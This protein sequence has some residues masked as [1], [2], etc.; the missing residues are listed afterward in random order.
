VAARPPRAS[1]RALAPDRVVVGTHAVSSVLTHQARR[2]EQLFV[3]DGARGGAIAALAVR[4]QVPVTVRTKDELDSL[5]GGDLVHQGAV[6]ACRPFTF[7]DLDDVVRD[8]PLLALVLDGVVDPRNFGRAVRSAHALGASFV[9][10]PDRHAASPTAAA[11]KASAGALARVPI[12]RFENL[13]RRLD[14][15]KA[16]GFWIVGA[17]ADASRAPWEV[18]LRD[19]IALVVGGEDRGLRRLTREACD[20]VVSIPMG[21]EDVSLN[22]ADAATLLLYEALR[23]RRA[24]FPSR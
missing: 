24:G 4:A 19:R 1:T 12:V 5:A 13:R 22:A 23:Q 20:H 11:Y 14:D 7:A 6:L 10:I 9:A 2:A 8:G 3:D 18:D 15:L 21:A 17:E 16:R